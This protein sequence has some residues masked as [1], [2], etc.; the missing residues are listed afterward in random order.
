MELELRMFGTEEMEEVFKVLPEAM[1]K[2]VINT[3]LRGAASIVRTAA[4]ANLRGNNSVRTGLLVRSISVKLKRYTASGVVWAGV[5]PDRSV[6]G[7]TPEGRRIVPANYAHLVERG[8]RHVPPRP[9]LRPAVDNN[10][11]PALAEFTR[12]ARKGMAREI[13]KLRAATSKGGAR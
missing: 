6:V 2:R 3:A 11:D 12:R 10:F 1:Q 4:R 5:G 8:T 13:R 7:T 9:F